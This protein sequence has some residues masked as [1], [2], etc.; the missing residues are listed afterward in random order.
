MNLARITK[1]DAQSPYQRKGKIKIMTPLKV[2]AKMLNPELKIVVWRDS[3]KDGV[4]KAR[5][6]E[7][8][9]YKNVILRDWYFTENEFN[10]VLK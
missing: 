8:S 5:N 3:Y 2:I 4:V 6:V 10:A 7:Q 1:G 9:S